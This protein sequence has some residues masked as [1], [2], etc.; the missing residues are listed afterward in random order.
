MRSV[1]IVIGRVDSMGG[2]CVGLG[3]FVRAPPDPIVV[4][5]SPKILMRTMLALAA[6]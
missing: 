6:L 2:L 4:S 5:V 1:A 3:G